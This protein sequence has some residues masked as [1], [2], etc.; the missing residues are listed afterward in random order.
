[1]GNMKSLSLKEQIKNLKNPN[2]I[3]MYVRKKKRHFNAYAVQNL[4]DMKAKKQF[5][6]RKDK[7][8]YFVQKVNKV[9]I[10]K[11]KS[12][13]YHV[14]QNKSGLPW[15]VKFVTNK[16]SLVTGKTNYLRNVYDVGFLKEL[17]LTP[18]KIGRWKV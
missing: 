17:G 4:L 11:L 10:E 12:V 16:A 5:V 1:M 9:I 8:L 7:K 13:G 15:K 2:Y 14:F 3:D 18:Q 6:V